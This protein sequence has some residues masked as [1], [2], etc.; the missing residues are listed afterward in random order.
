[1]G[2]LLVVVL[3]IPTFFVF[4]MGN[5]TNGDT[6][7]D[8]SAVN[9]TTNPIDK[10]VNQNTNTSDSAADENSNASFQKFENEYNLGYG[11]SQ[12]GLINGKQQTSTYNE[13]TFNLEVERLFNNGI[14][15]DGNFNM[16]TGY[17]Q[18]DLGP[19]NGGNN[20]GQP[21]GQN[22]FMYGFALKGG[23][24]F[25]LIQDSL[26]II[27]Y[28]MFGRSSNLATSTVEG[29]ANNTIS[30]DYFYTGGLGTRL[31]YRI[32]DTFMIYADELYQYN[33]DNSGAIQTAQINLY[34]KSYAATNY[35]LTSTIG[36][37]VNVWESLQ[38]GVNG[39]Y[40]YFQPQSNISGL[41]YT[42][43]NIFGVMGTIGLTY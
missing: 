41:V 3:S 22:P 15:L 6:S 8:V 37:K 20:S 5:D 26:Q 43:N 35:E 31:D 23:Y 4:A 9:V 1:M 25:Q 14:W 7:T 11:Y 42:P 36:A 13:Q 40:T 30:A 18:E 21:F 27:P 24:A 12:G 38:L 34:G 16:V 33:W 32:N 28:A 39:F 17:G 29:N 2:K 19:L 10:N